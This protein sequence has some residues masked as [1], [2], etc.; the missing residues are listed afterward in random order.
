MK[1]WSKLAYFVDGPPLCCIVLYPTHTWNS[2]SAINQNLFQKNKMGNE[3]GKYR[4]Y[5]SFLAKAIEPLFYLPLATSFV[6]IS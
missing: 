2:R 1:Q 4:W 5:E 6:I 3:K